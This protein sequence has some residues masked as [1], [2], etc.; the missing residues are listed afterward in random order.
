MN[1]VAPRYDAL[2]HVELLREYDH[3]IGRRPAQELADSEA[4]RVT[5][6]GVNEHLLFWSLG[7]APSY[8]RN[9]G[10]AL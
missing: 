9:L 1:S 3:A 7:F 5:G 6:K 10:S 4:L 8:T 2:L